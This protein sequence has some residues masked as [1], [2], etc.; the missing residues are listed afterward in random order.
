[1]A[2]VSTSESSSETA[3]LDAPPMEELQQPQPSAP[4][5]AGTRRWV[6]RVIVAAFTLLLV[7]VVTVQ[8]VLST[9]IPRRILVAQLQRAMGLR[10]QAQSMSVSWTGATKLKGVALSLPLA[11]QAMLEMPE[12]DVRHTMVPLILIGRPV[13]ITSATVRQ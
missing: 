10:V 7:L 5:R 9:D 12:L 1:M 2:D 11:E 3:T 6:L 8:I 4:R 13:Q